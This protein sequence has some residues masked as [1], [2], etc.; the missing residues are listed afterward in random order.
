MSD[1]GR[2]GGSYGV[3]LRAEESATERECDA[4]ADAGGDTPIKSCQADSLRVC[5]READSGRN[6]ERMHGDDFQILHPVPQPHNALLPI[7][8]LFPLLPVTHPVAQSTCEMMRRAIDDGE[9]VRPR[10]RG[11][12]NHTG[13]NT[14]RRSMTET[15]ARRP[16]K[17]SPGAQVCP[18]AR[19]T[20]TA[21]IDEHAH[22]HA[23]TRRRL[24]R[25]NFL[26][27]R[28]LPQW[29]LYSRRYV[30]QSCGTAVWHTGGCRHGRAS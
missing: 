26:F 16:G 6:E 8:P 12:A 24:H 17:V 20:R 1:T 10:T 14:P 18:R 21:C 11:D 4:V 23:H 2:R 7:R 29:H 13:A 25:M 22:A 9:Q 3:N 30:E 28:P 15:T 5:G 27:S 19:T